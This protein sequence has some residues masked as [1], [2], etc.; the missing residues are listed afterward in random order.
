MRADEFARIAAPLAEL[1]D[2]LIDQ[3]RYAMVAGH[4]LDATV[5][6]RAL[7]LAIKAHAEAQAMI[8]ETMQG[9]S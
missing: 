7:Q 9:E 2:Y 3:Q 8:H 5:M 4:P 6:S 1:E